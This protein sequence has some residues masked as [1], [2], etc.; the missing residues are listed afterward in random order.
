MIVEPI[1]STESDIR[2]WCAEYL[3]KTLK[4]SAKLIDPNARFARLGMDSVALASFVV[5][6]EEWLRIELTPDVV[7]EHAT[8]AG[9]ARHLAHNVD[10]PA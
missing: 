1:S 5:G 3:A 8:I 10:R 6:L 2:A 9:L 4:R 7:F